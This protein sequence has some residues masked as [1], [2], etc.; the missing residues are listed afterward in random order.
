MHG[1]F[2][3]AFAQSASW[4]LALSLEA[5][6]QNGTAVAGLSVDIHKCFGQL[7]RPVLLALLRA[8]NAPDDLVVP[9]WDFVSRLKVANMLCGGWGPL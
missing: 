7:S 4:C 3:G 5:A 2:K 8:T 9:W 1:G 6:R